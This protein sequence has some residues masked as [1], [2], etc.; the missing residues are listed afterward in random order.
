VGRKV[1]IKDVRWGANW[2][3]ATRRA[4]REEM[5]EVFAN[6]PS[7]VRNRRGRTADWCAVLG[8]PMNINLHDDE[9]PFV[10]P[11]MPEGM[12]QEEYAEWLYQRRDEIKEWDEVDAE[13][14]PNLGSVVSVRLRRSELSAIEVA[15]NA[16]GMKLSTFI[17][18][19]ALAASGV[20]DLDAARR[21]LARLRRQLDHLS[22]HLAAPDDDAGSTRRAA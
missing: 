19:A 4:S 22:I 15:A 10:H 14:S 1:Q 13:I 12:T 18:Q 17:R 11:D 21:D 9:E 8:E 6:G 5:E 16:A 3:H 20:V 7:I 2:H